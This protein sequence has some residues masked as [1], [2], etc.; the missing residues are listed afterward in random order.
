MPTSGMSWMR[1][2]RRMRKGRGEGEEECREGEYLE[3]NI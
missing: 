3:L 2:R 1:K